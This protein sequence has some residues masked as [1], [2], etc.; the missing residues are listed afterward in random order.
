MRVLF[1][2]P[3]YLYR[4]IAICILLLCYDA[5]TIILGHNIYIMLLLLFYTNYCIIELC[6][7]ELRNNLRVV[8]LDR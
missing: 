4:E 5:L 2:S 7:I 1:I 6:K 8:L 3:G